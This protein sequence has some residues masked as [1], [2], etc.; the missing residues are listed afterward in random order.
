MRRVSGRDDAMMHE[1]LPLFILYP[2]YKDK[3]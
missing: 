3:K 1:N 2:H